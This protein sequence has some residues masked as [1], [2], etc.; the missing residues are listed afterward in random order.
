MTIEWVGGLTASISAAQTVLGTDYDVVTWVEAFDDATYPLIVY[1]EV[2]D[3]DFDHFT[4]TGTIPVVFIDK[5]DTELSE[6][7]AICESRNLSA[8]SD[9]L[10]N[11]VRALK[12]LPRGVAGQL[13]DP[14][15]AIASPPAIDAED[16]ENPLVWSA[17]NVNFGIK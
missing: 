8:F 13:A 1:Y 2:A 16:V 12:E 7:R 10:V 5:F 6:D 15:F 3:V 11:F 4:I 9:K 14:T 17:V